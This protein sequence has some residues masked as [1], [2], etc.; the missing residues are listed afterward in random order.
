MDNNFTKI[1]NGPT[2]SCQRDLRKTINT[3]S[4]L[5]TKEQK[6][7]YMNMNPT[8]PT[9][10]GLIKIHK[11]NAPIRPIVNGKQA[12]T[13]KIA[14]LLVKKL[15]QYIPLPNTFNVKNTAHLIQDLAEI[16]YDPDIQFASFGITNMY[17]NIPLDD[18]ISIISNLCTTLQTQ[19]NVKNE[20]I[21]LTKLVTQQNYLQF[22]NQFYKQEKGLAMGAPTSSIFSELVLQHIEHTAIYDILT[23]N[24]I[25]GYFR[26]E[27]D[28][29]IVYSKTNTDIHTVHKEFNR[30]NNDIQFTIEEGTNDSINFL[31][32]TIKKPDKT[33]AVDVYRKPTFTDSIIPNDS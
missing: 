27:D 25:L 3:C 12:P 20:I 7:K 26:Y 21:Q 2:K 28:I 14:K 10:R 16:T 6:W 24:H 30:I 17:T 31:D 11:P 23:S 5:V 19:D 32:I 9:I 15:S 18:L 29:L 33:I 8:A 4:T 1:K 22:S 13:Y